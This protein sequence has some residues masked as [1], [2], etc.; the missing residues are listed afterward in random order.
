MEKKT[1]IPQ[2]NE[3]QRKAAFCENNAVIS[4]GAGSGKTMVLANRFAWLIT[5]K[6]FKAD[7]ILTLTFTKKA[8]GQMFKRIHS[9]IS[10]IASADKGIESQRA[11]AAL[12]DFSKA[13][14]QTLDSYC[15]S[16]VKQCAPRYGISP[17][18]KIDQERCRDIALEI[19]YPYFISHRNHQAIKKLYSLSGPNDIIR[20]IF[21]NILINHCHIDKPIDFLADTKKQFNLIS[22]EWKSYREKINKLLS[23]I[24]NDLAENNKYLPALIPILEK[25]GKDN[26]NIPDDT[27]LQNYFN[28]LLSV[29]ADSVIKT[30]ESSPIQESLLNFLIMLNSVSKVNLRSGKKN[31]NPVKDNIKILKKYQEAVVSL[32]I[33]CMQAGFLISIT[34]ILKELQ[35]LYTERKRAESVLTFTDVAK[36][37]RT[38][39]LEQLDIRQ[40]EKESFK[41]IMI[42]EFQD[43]NELQKDI[44]FLLAEKQDKKNHDIPKADSLC[45][46]KLFFVGDEKQSIYMFRGADVSVFRKL[47]NEIKSSDHPLKI[48]YR[49]SSNL[50]NAFNIIFGGYDLC[51]N[52]KNVYASVFAPAQSQLLFEAEYSPLEAGNS[53]EDKTTEK[54]V[55]FCILNKKNESKEEINLLSADE[56]EARFTAEKIKSL[57]AKNYKPDDI[58]ILFRTRSSQFLYEK[59]LR[60]LS[61]PYSSEDVNDLFYG[62]PVNDII[63]VLRLAS[64]PTDKI[65]YAEMLRSPFAGLSLSGTA[66]CLSIYCDKNNNEPFN[67]I[68]SK[69]LD[70]FDKTQYLNG[71]KIYK[72]IRAKAEIESNSSLVN[73]LWYNVGYRY[74]TEWNPQ[75]NA[76]SELFN[77]LFHLAA[78]SDTENKSL[79]SFTDQ[80]ISQRDSGKHLSDIEI[81]LERPS[82]VHLMTI[83]KSKGLEFPVVFL[84]GCGKRSQNERIDVIYNSDYA[85]FV[86]SPPVP[87]QCSQFSGKRNNF[88]WEK[89]N[90]ETK[91]KRTAELRRLLYVGMTRA[92]KE[93]YITGSLE[94]KNEE[95]ITDFSL[96]IKK[97]IEEKL[98]KNENYIEGDTIINN[99]TMFGLLLHVIACHIPTIGNNKNIFFNL[100]EIKRIS[101]DEVRAEDSKNGSVKNN[102]KNLIEFIKNKEIYYKKAKIL[103]TPVI[104][105]NHLTPV[106]LKKNDEETE[107]TEVIDIGRGIIINKEFSGGKSNDIFDKV[108]SLINTL[109]QSGGEKSEKFNSGSFGTIAH[110]CV[111]AQLNK[112]EPI[113]PS[114]ISC[115]LTINQTTALLEAGTELAKRFILSPLGKIAEKAKIKECEFPFRSI[116]KKEGKEFFINGTID[117]FFDDNDSIH[118]VDFKTD[119]IEKPTE[120]TAQLSCYYRAVSTL[121]ANPLKK[122]SRIWL[123]YLRTGHAVEMT[124]IAKKYDLEKRVIKNNK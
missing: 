100:E 12:E 48:N 58:A 116:I 13:R 96:V 92:E 107:E 121:F 104:N 63:S 106:S 40:N 93:I 21:A 66:V 67:D 42:D 82:A 103:T 38:I 61:I 118:V 43:N 55:N 41:A 71:Q 9:I 28:I 74:E 109:S 68:T 89:A 36:L 119:S 81:P 16:I 2:L 80:I 23:D 34:E 69:H 6:G 60:A 70:D 124:Y 85:G 56:N 33:S 54:C 45:P 50:I 44:L 112:D 98:S 17:D 53:S 113:L 7:E 15:S 30:A 31:E 47:K 117:L 64:H 59:H 46:D 84:C 14:I 101:Q 86:F 87:S 8:A 24:K 90:D 77:Y 95:N 25:T 29:H 62:G 49:S 18:F 3:E 99:D 122:Q 19:S 120:H 111:E 108:D 115:L 83:H 78:V 4:A 73:E 65:A 57:L 5:E 114:N 79:A 110:I 94:I 37:S 32:V 11:K 39:L 102:K 105:D 72:S 26:F 22:L 1:N 91:L 75:T 20:E 10:Q 27:A 97:Y 35:R 51:S 123:Y 52:E 88:F 76:Y